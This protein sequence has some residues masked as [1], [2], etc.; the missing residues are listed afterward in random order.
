MKSNK[1]IFHK[2]QGQKHTKQMDGKNYIKISI[3]IVNNK[4]RTNSTEN[5][6]FCI[7]K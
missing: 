6:F 1:Y 3:D 7:E 4:K 5:K 2:Q